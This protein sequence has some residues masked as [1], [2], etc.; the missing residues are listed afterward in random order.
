M[1]MIVTAK[2]LSLE[3][4]YFAEIIDQNLFHADNARYVFEL[5]RSAMR[6]NFLYWPRRF[7]QRFFLRVEGTVR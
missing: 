3:D 6:H 5:L 1:S 4:E 7:G 2:N